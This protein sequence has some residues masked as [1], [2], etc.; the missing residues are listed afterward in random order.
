MISSALHSAPVSSTA[1]P[2][3]FSTFWRLT[4]QALKISKAFQYSWSPHSIWNTVKTPGALVRL[5]YIHIP[6]WMN[7]NTGCLWSQSVKRK[8]LASNKV[9]RLSQRSTWEQWQKE[10]RKSG[11]LTLRPH[12]QPHCLF[13]LHTGCC[14]LLNKNSYSFSRHVIFSI[15]SKITRI[16]TA[17][18]VHEN[19]NK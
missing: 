15:F 12:P 9:R 4:M 7:H 1:D 10:W 17:K 16:T 3:G 8:S 18:K 2:T 11:I 13:S 5:C 14:V 19:W 6:Q